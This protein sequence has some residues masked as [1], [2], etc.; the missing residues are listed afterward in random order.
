M[1]RVF[2]TVALLAVLGTLA[3]SCQKEFCDNQTTNVAENAVIH[4][5]QY[6]INGVS[7][8]MTLVGDEAWQAFLERMLALAT[9]GNTITFRDES[10]SSQIAQTKDV[11]TYTTTNGD[12][13]IEWAD[14]MAQLGYTVTIEYDKRTG[15]YTCTAFK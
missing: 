13:A 14:K 1:K 3:V 5:V 15:I 6:S 9:E 12:D 7:Y 2:T 11:V 10:V 8:R 4:Y